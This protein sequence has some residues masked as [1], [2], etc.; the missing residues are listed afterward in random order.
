MNDSHETLDFGSAAT[1]LCSKDNDCGNDAAWDYV[2]SS[3]D[4]PVVVRLV[5]SAAALCES[6][7]SLDYASSP[8]ESITPV[9][10]HEDATVAGRIPASG[11]SD[12]GLR[13]IV[14]DGSWDYSP[15]P[16]VFGLAS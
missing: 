11:F 15:R 4:Q 14:D 10:A 7:A 2:N 9:L 12:D 1:G 6:D 8:C 16:I 3:K 13:A 5:R